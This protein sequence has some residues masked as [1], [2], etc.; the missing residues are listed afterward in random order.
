[1]ILSLLYKNIFPQFGDITNY[2]FHWKRINWI[3]LRV[4]RQ[5][6]SQSD[7]YQTFWEWCV[8]LRV[9]CQKHSESD[10][11]TTKRYIWEKLL[12]GDVLPSHHI[13]RTYKS[14]SVNL[15]RKS[16]PLSGFKYREWDTIYK[17]QQW[18][19][20]TIWLT[21]QC[22]LYS[23]LGM[24]H[25]S[26]IFSRHWTSCPVGINN[27]IDMSHVHFFLVERKFMLTNLVKCT[28]SS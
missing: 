14:K 26:N 18:S 21:A 7:V 19:G 5:K 25:A 27:T 17:V 12:I 20:A 23:N 16:Q 4:M 13:T 2:L 8:W 15:K 1:M 22:A 9:M 24:I 10:V 3:I 11:S 28:K 6:H